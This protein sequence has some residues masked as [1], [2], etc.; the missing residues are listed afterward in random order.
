MS[1][2]CVSNLSD[3]NIEDK[4]YK[5][6]TKNLIENASRKSEDCY[7]TE[8]RQIE[9]LKKCLRFLKSGYSLYQTPDLCAEEI[10][11]ALKEIENIEGNTDKEEKLGLIFSKF[12]IGK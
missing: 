3:R 4:V 2:S 8:V 11:L 12:C 5:F 7:F 10:R 9:H 1:I 6:I